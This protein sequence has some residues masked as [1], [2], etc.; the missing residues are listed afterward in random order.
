MIFFKSGIPIY[1]SKVS[2]MAG[3][4]MRRRRRGRRTQAIAKRYSFYANAI[5]QFSRQ[6]PYRILN[7]LEMMSQNDVQIYL[8]SHF[9]ITLIPKVDSVFKND[10]KLNYRN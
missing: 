4:K 3:R 8:I 5:I 7:F 10:F 6:Y 2:D 1:Y 9:I